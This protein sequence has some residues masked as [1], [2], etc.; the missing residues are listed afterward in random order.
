[1]DLRIHKDPLVNL[2]FF[3]LNQQKLR[4]GTND[5]WVNKAVAENNLEGKVDSTWCQV[6]VYH[7]RLYGFCK[8]IKKNKNQAFFNTR[9]FISVFP[10]TGGFSCAYSDNLLVWFLR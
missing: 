8:K 4:W 1:M 10:S 7:T 9:L 2:F 3:L 6:K 5:V